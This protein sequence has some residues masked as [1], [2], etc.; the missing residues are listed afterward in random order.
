MPDNS[1]SRYRAR[2]RSDPSALPEYLRQQWQEMA[3][4]GDGGTGS[5]MSAPGSVLRDSEGNE[6]VLLED[7]GTLSGD[8]ANDGNIAE[9][10]DVASVRRWDPDLG[11]VMPAEYLNQD[12][13][14]RRHRRSQAIA[15]T[16][17][18]G[19]LAGGLLTAG[20]AG[21]AGAGAVAPEGVAGAAGAGGTGAGGLSIEMLPAIAQPE[22]AAMG[23]FPALEGIGATG[24][25]GATTGG[26]SGLAGLG[27]AAGTPGFSLSA[28]GT[29]GVGVDSLAGMG[30]DGATTAGPSLWD[31]AVSSLGGYQGIARG[32]LGLASLGAAHEGGG[33]GGETNPQSIIE[34]MANANRVNHNTPF[35]SRAWSQ[36]ADGRWTVNDTLSP[37]E[38]ANYEGVRGINANV[39]GM[40]RDRLAALLAAPPRQRYD[41]PLGS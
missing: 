16:M 32:A 21:A 10:V 9:G 40:T 5:T 12:K 28:S 4:S 20:A 15:G 18:A 8:V 6:V 36:G 14:D 29:G 22:M 3:N 34:Q 19:G 11:W 7:N 1:T 35:G 38:Q 24:A 27:E 37:E 30:V 13:F 41:R 39:T 31:R 17:M 2:L 26:A 23:S 25:A 33:N